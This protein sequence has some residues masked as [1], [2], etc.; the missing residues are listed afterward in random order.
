MCLLA[1]P[2]G[3]WTLD[4]VTVVLMPSSGRCLAVHRNTLP[5]VVLCS[6]DLQ[7]CHRAS[8]GDFWLSAGERSFPKDCSMVTADRLHFFRVLLKVLV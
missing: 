6:A 7:A 5:L 4:A 1:L 3:W 2:D 8:Y